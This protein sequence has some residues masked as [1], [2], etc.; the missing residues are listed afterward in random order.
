M[1]LSG[2]LVVVSPPELE[3]CV[4]RLE[5]LPGIEVHYQDPL[6]GRLVITQEASTV[7]AEV[8][9]LK[10]IQSL[11]GV[12]LAAFIYHWFEEDTE[13][14]WHSFADDPMTRAAV[15][16]RSFPRFGE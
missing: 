12:I 6:T 16:K 2:I 10:R 15:A 13:L 1:N 5:A 9:G 14:V 4:S 11:S 7:N 8:E 3:D